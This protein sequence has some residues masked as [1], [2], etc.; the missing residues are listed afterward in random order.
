MLST[1]NQGDRVKKVLVI[2]TSMRSGANSDSLADEF[3]KGAKNGLD[4]QI[5]CFE[6]TK[7]KGKVFAGGVTNIGDI[8]N[9]KALKNAY[10]MGLGV[11]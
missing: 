3:V 9:S 2:S 8:K 10:D 4:G 1:L 11:A 6:N 7:F 5:S